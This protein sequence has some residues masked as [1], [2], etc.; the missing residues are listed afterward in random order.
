MAGGGGMTAPSKLP[1]RSPP[2]VAPPRALPLRL[3]L[4]PDPAVTP[5]AAAALA[6]AGRS[7][8]ALSSLARS[9]RR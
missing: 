3:V 6:L 5:A 2:A 1:R 7:L 8:V 9:E 4:S